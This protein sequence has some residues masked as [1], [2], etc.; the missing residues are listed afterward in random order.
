[1][2]T[3]PTVETDS[4]QPLKG[5]EDARS[6]TRGRRLLAL[7][8]V[9]AAAALVA[10]LLS[11][12]FGRDPSIVPSVHLDR[13]APELSGETLEGERFDVEDHRG[14]VVV[15]N[16]WASW[17]TACKEEHPDLI[18]A[19][20][21]L[22]ALPVQFV[23]VNFQDTPEDAAAALEEMGAYPYPSVFDP[24]GRVGLDWGIF[25][26]PETFVVDRQMRVRAKAT[27]PVTEAWLV[28]VVSTLL[29]EDSSGP[30]RTGE[31]G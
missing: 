2:E 7:G 5:G 15:V 8:G 12:G 26:V 24:G 1:M 22:Q 20:T 25:G 27:G 11:T 31:S 17:C 23:G 30:A 6:G 16:F 29:A 13:P 21:R 3:A 14:D 19:A 9:L 28:G 18:A 10:S 4:D